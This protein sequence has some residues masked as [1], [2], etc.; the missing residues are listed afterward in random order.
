MT[1]A[2]VFVLVFGGLLVLR[3]I[4]ATIFFALILPRGDRCLNC[5][6]VTLRIASVMCDRVF[7][8]FR[9]SWCLRCGWRGVLRRGPA[10]EQPAGVEVTAGR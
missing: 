10:T 5:D 6:A 2:T 8:W 1:E 3:V 7:P 9:R 4:L